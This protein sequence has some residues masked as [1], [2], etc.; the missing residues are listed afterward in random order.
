MIE[1]PIGRAPASVKLAVAL[2]LLVFVVALPAHRINWSVAV[3]PLVVVVAALGRISPRMLLGRTALALPFILGTSL[4][5]LFQRNG[6]VAFGTIAL[7]ATMA[8]TV[9]QV[10]TL[11]TPFP[12]LLAVLRRARLPAVLVTTLGLLY[13]YLFLLSDESVR[14]RRARAARTFG[15]RRARSWRLRAGVVGLLFVR[16]TLRAERIEA[17]MRARGAT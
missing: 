3:V 6:L 8:V 14:M 7:R 16:S 12:E 2:A 4:L 17:A 10:L 9:V 5:A 1:T 11:T 15:K 13:R